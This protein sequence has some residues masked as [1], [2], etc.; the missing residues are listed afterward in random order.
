MTN[1]RDVLSNDDIIWIAN[2]L[3]QTAQDGEIPTVKGKP[4]KGFKV[5]KTQDRKLKVEWI[6]YA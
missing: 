6:R 1:D 3:A 5:T 2:R 4:L